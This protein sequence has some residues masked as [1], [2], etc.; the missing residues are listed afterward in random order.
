MENFLGSY[1][2]RFMNQTLQN[3]QHENKVFNLI[4]KERKGF[5]KVYVTI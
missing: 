1:S 3:M 5:L 4:S 2:E